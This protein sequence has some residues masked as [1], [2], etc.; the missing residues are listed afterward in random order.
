MLGWWH[1]IKPKGTALATKPEAVSFIKST[2][3]NPQEI[4]EGV[5]AIAFRTENE[6][7]HSVFISILEFEV[8]VYSPFA[9]IGSISAEQAFSVTEDF[10][11]GIGRDEMFYVVRHVIPFYNLDASQVSEG[12]RI[13]LEIADRIKL[14]LG[15]SDSL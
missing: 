6:R 1:P 8:W 10:Y 13:I 14:T 2:F 15:L 9:L 5:F 12:V 4:S 3:D 7:K 11:Y